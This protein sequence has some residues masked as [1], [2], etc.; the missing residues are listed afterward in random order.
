MIMR[1]DSAI[2]VRVA[3]CARGELASRLLAVRTMRWLIDGP[4]SDD[5]DAE[6]RL[7]RELERVSVLLDRVVYCLAPDLIPF[8]PR[9]L[10]VA[11]LVASVAERFGGQASIQIDTAHAPAIADRAAL[12]H[13]LSSI[14]D[15]GL[16]SSDGVWVR[17]EGTR[18]DVVVSVRF[19]CPEDDPDLVG[20]LF[21]PV[22]PSSSARLGLDSVRTVARR[23]LGNVAATAS[24]GSLEVTLSL[25]VGITSMT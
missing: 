4:G 7:H 10:D 2:G 1:P 6:N 23:H 13:A 17:V 22:L 18:S 16:W 5:S 15:F 8:S 14:I 12:A 21:E 25:P 20:A 19:S 11:E 24:G 3:A 9:E